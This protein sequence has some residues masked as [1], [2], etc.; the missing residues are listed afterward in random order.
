MCL[1]SVI[2]ESMKTVIASDIHGSQ[3]WAERLNELIKNEGAGRLILLGDLL[4]HGPRNSLP[5]EYETK[6][7]ARILNELNQKLELVA[8][9]GNCDAE[10]D[11]MM[12][13]F[14]CM[15]DYTLIV[16]DKEHVFFATH[17]HLY[18][19]QGR[20][21]VPVKFPN[22]K[23]VCLTGHTHIKT[24]YVE[25]GIRFVNPGSTSIPKDGTHSCCVYENG[26]FRFINLE[27]FSEITL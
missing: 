8:V 19:P 11:Q 10:V 15:A 5:E 25:R 6:E 4:Y 9:R 26:N 23:L 24:N 2:I 13:D 16:P 12:L 1:Q 27:D 17:G 3:H 7:V 14:P 18:G 20:E 22:E 21:D